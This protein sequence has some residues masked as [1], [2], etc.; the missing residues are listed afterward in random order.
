MF[1]IRV[2]HRICGFGVGFVADQ[3][4]SICLDANLPQEIPRETS[5]VPT[6]AHVI[7]DGVA[8]LPRPILIVP[9]DNHARV[10]IEDSR[11]PV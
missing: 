8:H 5:N 11:I 2:S 9:D 7:I 4:R 6:V 3:A 10:P 1:V